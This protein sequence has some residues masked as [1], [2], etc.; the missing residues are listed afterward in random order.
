MIFLN[1]EERELFKKYETHFRIAIESNY[2]RGISSTD[3]DTLK[4]IY[5]KYNPKTP[6]GGNNNCSSCVLFNLKI[7]GRWW[8]TIK[9]CNKTKKSLSDTKK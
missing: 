3:L 4:A 6:I 5:N 9:P 8:N 2:C 7:L 1:S